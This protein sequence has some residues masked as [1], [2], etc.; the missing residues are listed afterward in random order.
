MSPEE[1]RAHLSDVLASPVFS[2]A[3]RIS[4]FLRFVVEASLE[5]RPHQ[6]SEFAIGVE[7]YGRPETFDPRTDAI[8]RVEAGRLRSKLREYYE[9]AAKNAPLRITFSKGSYIPVFT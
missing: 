4:R 1:V 3:S 7:V 8:V 5:G 6:I 2:K 9:G